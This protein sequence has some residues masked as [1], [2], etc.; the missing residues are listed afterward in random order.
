MS[1]KYYH[2]ASE[3]WL[4]GNYTLCGPICL[5][6]ALLLA[7]AGSADA[8]SCDADN[9]D[10]GGITRSESKRTSFLL[11]GADDVS[12]KG[13][14]ASGAT[15]YAG[16]S[17]YSGGRFWQAG[18][19]TTTAPSLTSGSWSEI[20]PKKYSNIRTICTYKLTDGRGSYPVIYSSN[21]KEQSTFVEDGVM[22]CD[23]WTGS[24]FMDSYAGATTWVKGHITYG[25]ACNSN[26][27]GSYE[28]ENGGGTYPPNQTWQKYLAFGPAGA[29]G[30]I[31]YEYSPGMVK[32]TWG[33][34]SGWSGGM[35]T[36]AI[37]SGGGTKVD[38]STGDWV[39]S[40]AIS[41]GGSWGATNSSHYPYSFS[42]DVIRFWASF[43]CAS[44]KN[45]FEATFR[46]WPVGTSESTNGKETKETISLSKEEQEDGSVLFKGEFH[47]KAGY[48]KRLVKIVKIGKCGGGGGLAGSGMGN[49]GGV[50]SI[51]WRVALGK[52]D[53]IKTVGWLRIEES[54]TISAATAS[55]AALKCDSE[56]FD[57]VQVFRDASNTIRQV[58]SPE[59]FV[60][61]VNGSGFYEIRFYDPTDAEETVL[62]FP[63]WTD[64]GASEYQIP[65]GRYQPTSGAIPFSVWR[66][67]NPSGSTNQV[68]ISH[69]VGG[70]E[71]YLFKKDG[72]TWSLD[73]NGEKKTELTK[74]EIGVGGVDG[75]EN[76]I[77]VKDGA[78]TIS[79]KTKEVYH[80][81]PFGKKIISRELDP[82]G[83]GLETTWT[84]YENQ[85]ADGAA[86]SKIK[87]VRNADG[88][89]V[90]YSYDSQGR[91]NKVVSSY[92]D[93]AP[94]AA[95]GASR[96]VTTN[97]TESSG[98]KTATIVET[99]KGQEVGRRYG[100][101][102]ADGSEVQ[103]IVC[104]K[105]G[106]GI[107]ASGNLITVTKY[108][109]SG[110]FAGEVASVLR[111][112]GTMEINTYNSSSG[113]KTT[114]TST[115]EPNSGGTAIVKGTK[116]TRTEDDLGEL[117]FEERDIASNFVLESYTVT[118]RD[119]LGRPEVISYNDG[120]S[121]TKTYSCCGVAS[122]TS[123]E[124]IVT[125]YTYDDLKRME[126]KSEG[127]L[128]WIYAYDGSG[129]IKSITRR[130]TD[131]SDIITERHDYDLAGRETDRWDAVNNHTS[132]QEE[133]GSGGG[134]VRT[135]TLPTSA[136]RIESIYRDGRPESI[137]G[138]G[139]HPLKYQYGTTSDGETLI[140]EIKIGSGGVE[141]EWVKSYGDM[142]GRPAR[143]V[144]A[145]GGVEKNFYNNRGQ[146]VR[147]VDAD[148]VVTV[149]GY[150]TLG[151]LVKEGI[152]LNGNGIADSSD[153]L[154][155]TQ[156][157]VIATGEV[158]EFVTGN[159]VSSISDT[160][161][162]GRYSSYTSAGTTTTETVLA[163]G[164]NWTT[165]TTYPDSSTLVE[166]YAA[167]QL[168]SATRKIG[169]TA[170]GTTSFQ[171]D[172]H[173]RLWKTTDGR[174]N[175]TTTNLY[176]ANDLLQS[177]NEGGLM[178]TSYSYNGLGQKTLE[179]LPGA[180]RTV[181]RDYWP[182]GELKSVGGTAEYPVSYT[183]D[184][185]GR[186]RTMSTATGVTTWNYS[187]SRGWLDAK[188]D[189][190]GKAVS[191]TY[192]PAARLLSRKWA[193]GVITNYGYDKYGDLKST[194]YSDGT[195]GV[196]MSYNQNGQLW[197]VSDT[198][199]IH[200]FTYDLGGKIRIDSIKNGVLGGITSN[201][202]VDSLYRQ[203]GF[204]A[205]RNASPLVDYTYTYD[206]ASRLDTVTSG[207]QS[208]QYA[209][210]ANSS[211][212]DSMAFKNSGSTVLT[213]SY[214][215]V[216]LDRLQRIEF[217]STGAGTKT[218]QY[219]Y[220]AFGLKSTVTFVGDSN[221]NHSFNQRGEV[222]TSIKRDQA[223]AQQLPGYNF[224]NTYDNIGNRITS[225]EN[226][227]TST[228]TT[229]GLNQ[230]ESRTVPGYKTVIGTANTGATVTVNGATANR[231]AD[232]TFNKEVSVDNTAAPVDS[233]ITVSSTL[234]S[235]TATSTGKIFFPQ[236]PETFTYDDDG[237]LTGD[238]RWTYTWDG[239]NRLVRMETKAAAVT[240][241]APRQRL[242]FQYD[243]LNRRIS[244]KVE[245]WNASKSTYQ[246]LSKTLFV[247]DGWKIVAEFLENNGP[248]LRS[249]VWGRDL[250]GGDSV[251]GIG[252]LLYIEQKSDAK[253]YAAGS[254][255]NGNVTYLY[256]MG[257]SVSLA[258]SYDYGPFGEIITES[259]P[260]AAT[261]PMRWSSKYQDEETDLSYFGHRYYSA[262]CARW[263]S[264]D[265]LGDSSFLL[266]HIEGEN[267]SDRY[268][269]LASHFRPEYVFVDNDP[270]NSF[271]PDGLKKISFSITTTIK[272]T[273]GWL[274]PAAALGVKTSHSF[275]V[276]D[277]TAK[278]SAQ[279]KYFGKTFGWVP[280]S[281]ALGADA[282]MYSDCILQ[283]KLWGVAQNWANPFLGSI[284]YIFFFT[285]D[286]STH[287]T[288][289]E[290]EHDGFPSYSLRGNGYAYNFNE[291]TV[292]RLDPPTEIKVLKKW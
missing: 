112:D 137:S 3:R 186:M 239:E 256:R 233:T 255:A 223:T 203:G 96:V 104:T 240:A 154:T 201:R 62:T 165:T 11:R 144:Y 177:V 208:V 271:D 40:P 101:K 38:T 260:F 160:N 254:D 141:T 158:R 103:E 99:I 56:S 83:A 257:S 191:Y 235:Q 216:E 60:D 214:N 39:T 52:V 54:T 95:E 130:G 133:I 47:A 228:Y 86:Y 74:T 278:I 178:S 285:I 202:R 248:V 26:S 128:T 155:E 71:V 143:T 8:Q 262:T 230:Y 173:G 241:G 46:E 229:N 132:F 84:Y 27:G 111:P 263:I 55:P 34:V 18:G 192:T 280:A 149:F 50:G 25:S 166:V 249:Y 68:K 109:I 127:G 183:Y 176:Y 14:F 284:D 69:T 98:V 225:V 273:A 91:E 196:S 281:G 89:W 243:Y 253:T 70:S 150:D 88:S 286:K 218:I 247:Y 92:L 220:N 291:I 7:I 231:R 116:V 4:A 205:S 145:G 23:G 185:Q 274:V 283:V 245:N 5:A 121:E 261:N 142:A 217:A 36:I 80:N 170:I 287:R 53:A 93:G 190:A 117:S 1:A 81:F 266:R 146:L 28:D 100:V 105:P 156:K 73:L 6:I 289:L 258:A 76:V 120:T 118:D 19:T 251:A 198:A 275:K 171:Y 90:R 82:D 182:S 292:D 277:E 174:L 43:G 212:V 169:S 200:T 102:N 215:F 114:I 276:D 87:E 124:G 153:R 51:W 282:R 180:S 226:S 126:T 42:S 67:E 17:V 272:R 168:T 172:A 188:V 15:Y 77:V 270:I 209:Y 237:N 189:A 199:G 119:D 13:P 79:S 57:Q 159:G 206:G 152:D 163:G 30:T 32:T 232:G 234:S 157:S 194:N 21:C 197:K 259:G 164:G 22:S 224:G 35:T 131:N 264:R 269:S 279:Y 110:E 246:Q 66:V 140:Q 252:G 33:A 219:G 97:Y 63:A 48:W 41:N 147:K 134:I 138:T 290:G 113:V 184:A 181:V 187:P 148:G 129:N 204:Y 151:E 16:Q 61:V 9:E 72:N 195:P 94:G 167:G 107:G 64:S 179:T 161:L 288:T 44:E 222:S 29:G 236:T 122:E 58:S 85:V 244:K 139:V 242:T 221:W 267:T 250:S 238:G 211:L 59:V 78:G 162:N 24:W 115:G 268:A 45:S 37:A 20:Q 193:R 265:P 106:A 207:S 175:V 12:Y 227:R 135:T 2:H 136:T 125:S 108:V 65:T 49:A 213:T 75:N 31:Q 10:V 123:R 210:K